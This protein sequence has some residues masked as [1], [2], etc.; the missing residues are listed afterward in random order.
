MPSV[1]IE[2]AYSQPNEALRK[3]A[4]SYLINSDTNMRAVIGIDVKDAKSCK[5]IFS[6]W[7]TR[8]ENDTELVMYAVTKDQVR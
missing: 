5:A 8:V 2:V 7:R 6:V 3:L 1:I 4:W